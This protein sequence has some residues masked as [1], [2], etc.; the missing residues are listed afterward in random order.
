MLNS[1]LLIVGLFVA[2]ALWLRWR[3]PHMLYYPDRQID[4]TPDKLGLK[5][6]DVTLTT[7][8]RREDQRLVCARSRIADHQSP[9][10]NH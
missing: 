10:T 3:E 4:Q 8:G 7:S 1:L 9:A 5:Y 2:L 6:E